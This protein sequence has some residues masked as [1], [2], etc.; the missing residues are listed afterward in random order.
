MCHYHHPRVGH[1]LVGHL[2][3]VVPLKQH[4]KRPPSFFLCSSQ[5]TDFITTRDPPEMGKRVYA[6]L[7]TRFPTTWPP[8]S[9]LNTNE[10]PY[11]LD[12]SSAGLLSATPTAKPVPPRG[13]CTS[14]PSARKALPPT[15]RSLLVHP[16]YVPSSRTPS[17]D[18]QAQPHLPSTRYFISSAR[19]YLSII[20]HS[21]TPVIIIPILISC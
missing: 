18:P 14:A 7:P 4:L 5:S 21:H 19:N 11:C 20:S 10:S 15:F 16:Q 17:L 12:P 1:H 3:F 6:H 13:L 8:A 9:Y 2:V